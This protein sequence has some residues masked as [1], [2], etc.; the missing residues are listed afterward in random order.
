[1]DGVQFEKQRDPDTGQ[2]H[3][4][5]RSKTGRIIDKNRSDKRYGYKTHLTRRQQK[6][7]AWALRQRDRGISR[8]RILAAIEEMGKR[9]G[10]GWEPQPMQYP[11]SRGTITS[12][13]LT[14]AAEKKKGREWPR[15]K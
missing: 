1:M 11:I 9:E 10:K 8:D 2:E 14:R 5:A 6:I 7:I 12:W 4:I 3:V 15:I 13:E